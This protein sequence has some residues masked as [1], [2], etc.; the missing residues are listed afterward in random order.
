VKEKLKRKELLKKKLK[1]P[2]KKVEHK[3]LSNKPN[4]KTKSIKLKNLSRIAKPISS[5]QKLS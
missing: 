5:H 4:P 3:L 1:Q 2:K